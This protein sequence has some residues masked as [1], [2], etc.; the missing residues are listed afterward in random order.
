[1][2]KK[3][4]AGIIGAAGY[5]GGEL[6]RLLPL[7]PAVNIAFAQSKSQAGKPVHSVHIDLI[8]ETDLHFSET[9]TQDVDVLFLCLAHGE[10]KTWLRENTIAASTHVIDL[11]Q[12]FRLQENGNDFVYGLPELQRDNIREAKHI[13]NPGCFATVIQLLLLPLAANNLLN[14]DVHVSAVTGSTGAGQALSATGHF[15]RRFANHSTYKEFSHQHLDEI[16]Q[17]I[18]Q[19]QPGFDKDILFIPQRGAFT[20][21]IHATAQLRCI[22]TQQEITT[23]YEAYYATHPFTHVCRESIELKQVVNTNR[24]LVHPIVHGDHLL[25]TGVIDNLLKGAAGQAVQNMNLLFGFDETA[26]LK[27]KPS[28]F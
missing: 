27:L 9:A 16:G 20:R 2:Q 26:G 4:T 7:H 15:S 5:T 10:A 28:A 19:L 3:I 18:L 1:M 17:S 12:D 22:H 13:A 23:L 24:C 21:G 25:L 6:L 8:G 11:S 14:D